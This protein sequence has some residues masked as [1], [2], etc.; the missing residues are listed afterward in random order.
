ME[1][2]G[3]P[4]NTLYIPGYTFKQ[5]TESVGPPSSTL[6]EP[7]YTFKIDHGVSQTTI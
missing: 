3:Q 4:S 7:C 5:I 1:S 6:Y 2:V